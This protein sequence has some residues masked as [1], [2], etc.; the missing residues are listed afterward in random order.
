MQAAPRL[1]IILPDDPIESELH[2][3][4]LWLEGRDRRDV[5]ATTMLSKATGGHVEAD[6]Y[7]TGDPEVITPIARELAG[8]GCKAIVWA[9]TSGSFIGGL[10]W[11]RRQARALEQAA[12]VPAT[13]TTLA[14]I[15]ALAALGTSRVHL[16]GA[17]PE[18]VTRALESCLA[19]AGVTVESLRALGTPD[20]PASFHLD[21]RAEVARFA[22][23]LD[24]APDQPILIPDTAINSL[25]LV[26]DLEVSSG[27]PV[28]T[29]NQVSLWHG[30]RLLGVSTAVPR[31]GHLLAADAA[32]SG[33]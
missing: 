30:L 14:F 19:E 12:G 32:A 10:A 16:L 6:L 22:A 25:A 17:Y 15:A 9:C 11:A 2:R 5:T 27:R 4:D 33:R 3:L 18:P 28:L 26:D 8:Q 29:A 1:G 13:S 7:Q 21:L 20:G 23:T 31:A 24:G